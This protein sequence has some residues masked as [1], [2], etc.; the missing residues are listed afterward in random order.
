VRPLG[1]PRGAA[2]DGGDSG[3]FLGSGLNP[4]PDLNLTDW[5]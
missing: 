4:R 2:S 3:G 1:H 5:N